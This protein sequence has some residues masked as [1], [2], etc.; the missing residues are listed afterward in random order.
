MTPSTDTLRET[1]SLQWAGWSNQ[2]QT[3]AQYC[4]SL[5]KTRLTE[6]RELS[7]A[8]ALVAS[9]ADRLYQQSTLSHHYRP[10]SHQMTIQFLPSTVLTSLLP[11]S[12]LAIFLIIKCKVWC[13]GQWEEVSGWKIL[14][15]R[16][17]LSIVDMEFGLFFDLFMVTEFQVKDM[18]RLS[19]CE[20]D[21]STSGRI[22]S[23]K[24]LNQDQTSRKEIDELLSTYKA[25]HKA[26]NQ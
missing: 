14:Q 20:E 7:T 15:H 25:L 9:I 2:A 13:T 10:L 21:E 23:Q 3:A 11:R 18:R 16:H 19:R 6:W 17:D 12:M 1:G 24:G 4:I 8:R 22:K 26:F 5:M